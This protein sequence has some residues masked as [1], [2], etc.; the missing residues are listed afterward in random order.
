MGPDHLRMV[1]GI[2]QGDERDERI[3]HRREDR[4][5]A[6]A[7]LEALEHPGLGPFEGPFTEGMQALPAHP[8]GEFVEPVQPQ[9]DVPQREVEV[10]RAEGLI[11]FPLAVGVELVEVDLHLPCRPEMVDDGQ[12]D[13]HG[14]RPVAH[15]P[16]VDM[17]PFADEEHLARDGGHVVP[18]HQAD[19]GQVELRK[20]V[21]PRH[22][23]EGPG[24]F[25]G[26][27]HAWIGGGDAGQF[28]R[29]VGLDRGV[30]LGRAVGVDV[31]AAVAE[32]LLE[33]VMDGLALPDRVHLP[34][35]V[36]EGHHVGD[37]RHV[38]HQLAHPVTLGLLL[39]KQVA[40]GSGDR[41]VQVGMGGEDGPPLGAVL[42]PD[43]RWAH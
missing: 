32:L 27:E 7:A 21:H 23:A 16:E 34:P 11:Q 40:L 9:E 15:L 14:P 36:V 31:P 24:H 33:D 3:E 35:P 42:G 19:E 38:D 10:A 20:G 6:V 25:P 22:A 1:V 43:R 8:L 26:A 4:G 41:G 30:H 5:Q 39:R 29:Q 13:D 17:E 18:G 2:A 28:Q 37:Q 12:R